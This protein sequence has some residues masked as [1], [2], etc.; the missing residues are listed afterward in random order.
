MSRDEFRRVSRD[1]FR[2]LKFK[3]KAPIIVALLFGYGVAAAL[4]YGFSIWL[5]RVLDIPPQT[6]LSDQSHGWL[7]CLLFLVCFILAVFSC[8][9][10]MLILLTRHWAKRHCWSREQARKAVLIAWLP[11]NWFRP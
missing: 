10:G 8:C 4:S 3:Y 11:G 6:S 9:C 7:W 2:R 5:A 1:E